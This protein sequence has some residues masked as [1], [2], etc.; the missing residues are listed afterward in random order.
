MSLD[1]QVI[2]DEE[3]DKRVNMVFQNCFYTIAKDDIGMVLEI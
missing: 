2:Q 1:N 3:D